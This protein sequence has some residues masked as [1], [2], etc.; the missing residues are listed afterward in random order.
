MLLRCIPVSANNYSSICEVVKFSDRSSHVCEGLVACGIVWIF[1]AGGISLIARENRV[2]E[3][4]FFSGSW[5]IG[6]GHRC[7]MRCIRGQRKKS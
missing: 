4:I 5:I 3:D 6:D 7:D 2:N 1:G